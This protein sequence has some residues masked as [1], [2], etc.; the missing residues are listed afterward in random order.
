MEEITI[1]KLQKE[2]AALKQQLEKQR[3]D[4][5][6]LARIIRWKLSGVW[7]NVLQF[8]W[9][10]KH[11]DFTYPEVREWMKQNLPAQEVAD[12]LPKDSTHDSSVQ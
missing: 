1:E 7:S 9:Y 4:L 2:N 11:G 3:S 10:A 5:I 8:D 12:E 6:L